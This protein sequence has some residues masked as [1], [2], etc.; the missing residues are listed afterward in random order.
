MLPAAKLAPAMST[1]CAGPPFGRVTFMRRAFS[2]TAPLIPRLTCA[3]SP[4]GQPR[5]TKAISS[6][7]AVQ[8]L[9]MLAASGARLPCSAE[10]QAEAVDTCKSTADR[11]LAEAGKWLSM[12]VAGAGAPSSNE[13]A[14]LHSDQF[15]CSSRTRTRQNQ[16]SSL[17]KLSVVGGLPWKGSKADPFAPACS[18]SSCTSRAKHWRPPWRAS[19]GS[20]NSSHL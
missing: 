8:P 14:S 4:V 10:A 16:R 2:G 15:N 12:A 3:V 18:P 9:G 11:P 7:N 19:A 1:S 17:P 13:P 20:S 6:V 5:S